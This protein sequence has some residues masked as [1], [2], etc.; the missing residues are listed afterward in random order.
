M[1]LTPL[2]VLLSD[3]FL[4]PRLKHGAPRPDLPRITEPQ[5]KPII[6]AGFG[7]YGQ[8]IGRLLFANGLKA[9]VLEHD[10]EQ[11]DAVRRFGWK[12]FYGDATRLDLLR[13]AGAEQAR[14][15][16]VAIDDIEQSLA[17]VR[18]AREHFPRLQVVARARNVRHYYRLRDL[19]VTLIERE[20]LDS[21]LMSGRSV[22]E[23]MGWQPHA[24]RTQAMRFRRHNVEQLEQMLPFFRDEAKLIAMSR[25]GREQLEA[26]WAQERIEAGRGGVRGSWYAPAAEEP[27]AEE[28]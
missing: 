17:I 21:A 20:T 11:V 2:L 18:L 23:L 19:G 7:R 24:A 10:A 13:T 22:L 6:I 25:E 1:L 27:P 26:L 4:V 14:V 28:R 3:R 15:M 9:T 5:E 8:I 12:V 16:V